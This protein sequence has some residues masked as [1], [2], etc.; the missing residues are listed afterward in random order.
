MLTS[1]RSKLLE[2]RTEKMAWVQ[3]WCEEEQLRLADVQDRDVGGMLRAGLAKLHLSYL[4]LGWEPWPNSDI[5]AERRE[6][7]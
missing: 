4:E 5:V 2:L 6:V 7:I 1:F 3:R